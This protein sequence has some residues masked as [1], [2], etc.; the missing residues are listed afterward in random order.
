MRIPAVSL[1]YLGDISA[2]SQVAEAIMRIC[3]VSRLHLGDISAISRRYLGDISG[4]GGDHAHLLDADQRELCAEEG[5]VHC[6]EPPA[7]RPGV[8][9]DAG[10]ISANISAGFSASFSASFSVIMC[11]SLA[12]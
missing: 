11:R 2:A 10:A 4:G 3:S 1:R 12:R 6:M 9:R 5:L 8:R 7:R